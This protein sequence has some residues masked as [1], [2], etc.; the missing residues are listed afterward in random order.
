MSTSRDRP[1]SKLP[2]INATNP[3]GR[4][5]KPSLTSSQAPKRN[6]V[7]PRPGP[8]RAATY[9]PRHRPLTRWPKI[10]TQGQYVVAAGLAVGIGY[11]YLWEPAFA[12]LAKEKGEK[13]EAGMQELAK[14][15][16]PSTG[17]T[18]AGGNGTQKLAPA[19]S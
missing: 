1:S 14:G 7:D 3:T 19:G 6:P 4:I 2:P 17:P 11:Y 13:S 18:S 10:A 16:L 8:R 12:Q 9:T 5:P 15:G